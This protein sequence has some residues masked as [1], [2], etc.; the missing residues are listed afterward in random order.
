MTNSERLDKGI[1]V[2]FTGGLQ[3]LKQ[4]MMVVGT[5]ADNRLY[6]ARKP[7][8]RIGLNNTPR[9]VSTY[10]IPRE[11]PEDPRWV[12]WTGSGWSP[13]WYQCAPLM[14]STGTVITSLASVS[15]TSYRDRTWMATVQDDGSQRY[16]RIYSQRRSRPWSVEGTLPLGDSAAGFLDGLR[17]QPQISPSASSAEMSGQTNESALVYLYSTLSDIDGIATINNT[18][19]LWPVGLSIPTTST[20]SPTALNAT[21]PIRITLAADA[22]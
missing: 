15:L 3:L 20:E 10:G 22:L 21:V 4:N 8:S 17:F 5:D 12:Y 14:D 6:L 1:P 16:A 11:T 2:R 19:G 9:P 7:W 13:D 18:W